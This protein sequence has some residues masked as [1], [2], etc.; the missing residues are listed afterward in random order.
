MNPKYLRRVGTAC[1]LVLLLCAMVLLGS[2]PMA[3]KIVWCALLAAYSGF[4][5]WLEL[6]YVPRMRT[7]RFLNRSDIPDSRFCL[8]FEALGASTSE[9][10]ALRRDLADAFHI[11]AEK[12]QPQDAID[13][14]GYPGFVELM[15]MTDARLEKAAE[16]S[17]RRTGV[18]I[19]VG[20]V[21]TVNDYITAY[22]ARRSERRI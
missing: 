15:G 19:D 7:C 5:A 9:V 21:A 10:V 8:E 11:P 16:N 2:K 17:E 14:F 22:L 1:L 4:L 13:D 6:R 20:A 12:I 3:Y 18:R